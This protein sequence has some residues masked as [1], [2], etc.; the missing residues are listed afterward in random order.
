MF[1]EAFEL[2]TCY[3]RSGDDEINL[4]RVLD[5]HKVETGRRRRASDVPLFSIDLSDSGLRGEV[6]GK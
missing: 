4:E 3:T 5:S 6:V 2:M 1:K